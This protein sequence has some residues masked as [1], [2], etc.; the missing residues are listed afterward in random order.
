MGQIQCTCLEDGPVKDVGL[1]AKASTSETLHNVYS[2]I[3]N[4]ATIRRNVRFKLDEISESIS[5][6]HFEKDYIDTNCGSEFERI[7]QLKIPSEAKTHWKII[8]YY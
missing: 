8:K 4:D 3:M 2:Y 5:K 7:Q 6:R 1:L